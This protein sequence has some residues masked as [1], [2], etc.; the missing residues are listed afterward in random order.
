[1]KFLVSVEAWI[2]LAVIMPFWATNAKSG[3]GC[4]LINS[5]ELVNDTGAYIESNCPKSYVTWL[6]EKQI[7]IKV[8]EEA[9]TGPHGLFKVDWDARQTATINL[10][11][12][13]HDF[14]AES[15]QSMGDNEKCYIVTDTEKLN[16]MR[17][18]VGVW[19]ETDD[20]IPNVFATLPTIGEHLKI[21]DVLINESR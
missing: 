19:H 11:E 18:P 17:A 15:Q 16:E 6:G 8:V 10:L 14:C 9:K 5:L 20:A 7:S 13:G 12:I 1:M 3:S 2:V 21:S 4:A